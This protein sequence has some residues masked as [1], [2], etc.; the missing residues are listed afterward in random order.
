MKKNVSKAEKNIFPRKS[1][2][3]IR[4]SIIINAECDYMNPKQS[5]HLHSKNGKTFVI[6][7]EIYAYAV[8]YRRN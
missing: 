5:E 4:V 8:N 2:A 1:E 7:Q 6:L 3:Y